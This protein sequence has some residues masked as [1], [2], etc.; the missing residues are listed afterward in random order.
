MDLAEAGG[1]GGV[2][3]EAFELGLPV[4]AEFGFHAA[5]DE[6][7]AH[8]RGVR[9]ELLERPG[10]FRREGFGNG[11]QDL[12][13]FHQG[14]FEVAQGVHELLGVF[15]AFDFEAQIFFTDEFCAQTGHCAGDFAVA[16]EAAADICFI[17][18][19]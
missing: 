19:W 17:F 9:L 12:P 5:A 2:L 10:I 11:G 14:A 15:F 3:F 1:G 8:W 6:G 7:P 18:W 4:C 16:D 13:D